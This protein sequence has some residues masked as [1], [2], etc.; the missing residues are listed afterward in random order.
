MNSVS[1]P[2]TINLSHNGKAGEFVKAGIIKFVFH[3]ALFSMGPTCVHKGFSLVS[4]ISK[5]GTN[6]RL[7]NTCKSGVSCPDTSLYLWSSQGPGWSS[8]K[9]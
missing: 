3:Q 8:A 1:D 2:R 7:R 6:V 5:N 4:Y 9:L